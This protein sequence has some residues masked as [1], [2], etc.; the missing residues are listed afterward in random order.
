MADPLTLLGGRC[1]PYRIRREL[2]AGAMGTVY[3][4]E[5]EGE[6]GPPVALKLFHPHLLRRKGF[7]TRFRREAEAGRQVDH[8]N[9]VRTFDCDLLLVDG[10]LC[11]FL[12]MEYAEG[13]TLRDLQHE[14]GKVPEGLLREIAL[15]LSAG[16][17]AIHA[18]EIVHRDLKPENVLFAKDQRIRI[19]DLG[20]AKVEDTSVA[21]TM[22][23]KFAG[24][25]LY[26]APE[27]IRQEPVGPAAD[28]YSLGVMLYELAAGENPFQRESA[29]GVMYAHLHHEPPPLQGLSPF[30]A[31]VIQ[32]LLAKAPAERFRSAGVLQRALEE[33]EKSAWW[34]ERREDAEWR[35]ARK[36]EIPVR[37]STR[38]YGREEERRLLAEAWERARA[39]KGSLVLLEGEAGIGKTRLI[40]TFAQAAAREGAT[41]LYGS[42]APAGGGDALAEAVLQHFGEE[43]L[44][45][46][47]DWYLG[48]V[49]ALLP[50]FV[51]LLRQEPPPETALEGGALHTVWC[52]LMRG[53]STDRPLVWIA[54]D[55]QFASAESRRILLAM[56]RAARG[57]RVL[58]IAS[59]RSPLPH[60]ER[61]EFERLQRFQRVLLR[62]LLPTE[63]MQLLHDAFRN[64]ELAEK[65]GGRIAEKSD[66]VPFFVCEMIRGLCERKFLSPLPD[67]RFV[68]ARAIGRIEVPSEVRDLLEARL[69][70]VAPEERTV[71]DAGAVQGY[72]F[73]PGVTAR[74][75]GLEKVTV[76]QR[77]ALLERRLGVLRGQ[78]R[79]CRFDHHLVQEIL[80]E[81]M[82]PSLRAAYHAR[83]GDAL[84]A[85][86]EV[87][88][89]R[90]YRLAQHYLRGE[91]P[92]KAFPFLLEALDH[93][94]REHR[95]QEKLELADLAL[96][97]GAGLADDLRVRVLLR[98]A[99]ALLVLGRRAENLAVLGDA[100]EVASRL[101]D[102]ALKLSAMLEL[103]G[104]DIEQI[105]SDA[106]DQRITGALQL[107][108][109]LGNAVAEAKAQ[110]A[111]GVLRIMQGQ[112]DEGLSSLDRA[113]SLAH[114][115]GDRE[116]E[117]RALANL[118]FGMLR[119]GRNE[120]AR[121]YGER[122]VLVT[123]EA[124]R[125]LVGVVAMLNLAAAQSRLGDTLAAEEMQEEALRVAESI[126]YRNGEAMAA[127]DLGHTR[128]LLGRG[129]RARQC[130]ERALTTAREIGERSLEARVLAEWGAHWINVGRA[131][132]ALRCFADSLAVQEG[133]GDRVRAEFMRLRQSHLAAEL[134]RPD[135]GPVARSLEVLRRLHAVAFEGYGFFVL[136]RVAELRGKSRE[137]LKRY[138]QS[139]YRRRIARERP[140]MAEVL[141]VIGRLK[142][143][144]DKPADARLY[145]QEARE[146]AKASTL[147]N[148]DAVAQAHLALTP[149][150][151]VETACE[152]FAKQEMRIPH[153][154]RLAAC[155][156][157]WRA[158]GKRPYLDEAQRLLLDFRDGA[159]PE[160]R[161]AVLT[162]VP[163][164]AEI[165]EAA[166]QQ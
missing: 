4:A 71:L 122:S 13:Q 81:A 1:G 120:E 80:Y 106:A 87:T 89:R 20:V 90:A 166:R 32:T 116:V 7:F 73:D 43:R 28:L 8:P 10:R 66:G 22:D 50:A 60:A 76:L 112:L 37:R 108:R 100:L 29:A 123:R 117:A 47:L 98:K 24:S 161:Q 132:Q 160:S 48:D 128:N 137:A 83:V 94:G 54:E 5:V 101:D 135:P 77:I 104:R 6:A 162:G 64:R 42:F 14:L 152:M 109:Q 142:I 163:L 59:S 68:E 62:R 102:P 9:V 131:E 103:A 126:G 3:L 96:A 25:L 145:L 38:V 58:L 16:L 18:E 92:A 26:V 15:Q 82:L 105:D 118:G 107:A 151:D 113:A 70:D 148:L 136:G 164:H 53:L 19:M 11:F 143:R 138:R 130:F 84:V 45:D 141:S 121:A 85:A 61:E 51:A 88:G 86:G 57:L 119:C 36:V 146:V 46:E 93:L 144:L 75:L 30:L 55:L 72:E 159:P 67:G 52:Q 125:P 165:L 56:L 124:G 79:T 21:I 27:Q 115:A 95:S 133:L 149:G 35:T 127:M 155:H 158:S 154:E 12:V 129:A 99:A 111:L 44:A 139:L 23:G 40:D 114:D 31:S 63:V 156:A 41:V 2:G 78:E 34:Q 157:L 140:A 153:L 17:A 49:A 91:D 147:P 97:P 110:T 150:G 33:A 74:V 69:S 134:G 39:G 65:L